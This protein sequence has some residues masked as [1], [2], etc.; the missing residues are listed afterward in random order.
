MSSYNV[1]WQC[2][3]NSPFVFVQWFPRFPDRKKIQ[4]IYRKIYRFNTQIYQ[5][6]YEIYKIYTIIQDIYKIP[7]RRRLAAAWYFVY[8]LYILYIFVY[9]CIYSNIFWYIWYYSRLEVR[10]WTSEPLKRFEPFGH[11]VRWLLPGTYFKHV[12]FFSTCLLM[13]NGNILNYVSK[14]VNWDK[15]ISSS[16]TVFDF[17]VNIDMFGCC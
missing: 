16:D 12:L 17:E 11:N 1:L 6:I 14:C 8:I 7:G 3:I 9:I 4:K 2:P 10:T 15:T 13:S 5:F